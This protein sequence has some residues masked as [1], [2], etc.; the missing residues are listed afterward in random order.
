MG[1]IKRFWTVL[2]SCS[3]GFAQ[4]QSPLNLVNASDKWDLKRCVDYAVNKN[5]NVR[6][7][8]IQRK[9]AE[10]Q[11]RQSEMS[12]WPDLNFGLNGGYQFGRSIDPTTNN[13]TTQN[14]FGGGTSLTSNALLFNWFGLKN[15]IAA[16][17]LESKA[18][19]AQV[20]KV[21]NDISLAVANA[22][23]QALLNREAINIATVQVKQSEAQLRNTQKQVLA[24][25]LPELNA[26]Q[27][28]AQLARDSSTLVTTENSYLLSLLQLK[29]LL[30]L[31]A[32]APFDIV[33][34]PIESIPVEPISEL[35][36]ESVYALAIQNQPLQKVNSIRKEA[37]EKRLAATRAQLYPSI[38]ASGSVQSNFLGSPPLTP[39]GNPIPVVPV[40]GK[41]TV[42]TTSYDVFS[43]R[44]INTYSSFSKPGFFQQ[45]GD[46]F[47]QSLG[48]GISVPIFNNGAA[49]ANVERAKLNM[50]NNDLI[51]E[52][53]NM[54]L[55]QD[56]YNAYTG[57]SG[58][59]QKYNA[60]L[61]SEETAKKAYEYASKRYDI[62]LAQ[63]IDLIT[64]QNNY[65]RARYDMVTA[66][67]E[68][69]FRLKVLEFYRGQGIKLTK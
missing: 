46:N 12:R 25:S 5:I 31:D 43:A 13:F 45:I 39:E 2:L 10:I 41:V 15:T 65:F 4:A 53:D 1:M 48:I 66:Q 55:K 32:G 58:A 34:P 52:R 63:T 24:G 33:A 11:L 51:I 16:D 54:Q 42:G 49:R 69:V 27:L 29:A 22:Y 47:R 67:T 8:D 30:N 62:G 9:L 56:I 23:L 28:E 17:A 61:R 50:A 64:A 38:S 36:P 19:A 3:I 57:A 20:D 59:L 6:Q 40:I 44:P 60:A 68:Y 21:R 37:L 14:L 7:T 18:A 26:A 35:Q